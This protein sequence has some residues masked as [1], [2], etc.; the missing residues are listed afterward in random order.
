M[1]AVRDLS[2]AGLDVSRETL[3]RLEA[4]SG[5]V[6]RWNPTV[7]LVSRQSLA[8][9]WGRHI[10]DSAQLFAFCPKTATHWVD[11]GSGGGFPG[12]VIA[13]LAKDQRPDLRVTLV[14]ADQRKATF[15]RQ[16]AQ[17]LGLDVNVRCARIELLPHL[18]ADV[19]SA[20]ALAPLPDLIDL[21]S[22]HLRAGGI[23]IFPKGARYSDELD[24]AR[25]TWALEVEARPSLSQT[26]SA[27]LIIR[28]HERA[29]PS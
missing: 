2:L 11:L 21:S 5:L 16:A 13:I 28:K 12:L 17:A 15:L 24:T 23:M 3:D 26:E 14:E 19:V 29:R 6:Q 7:N 20:R 27:I 10:I 18:G 8:D 1:M 22:R 25:Q 4:F 9:L